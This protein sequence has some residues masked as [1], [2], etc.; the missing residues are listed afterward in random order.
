LQAVIARALR[1]DDTL[2]GRRPAEMAA[3]LAALDFE[4]NE[5]RRLRL[6][7]DAWAMRLEV[8]REYRSQIDAPIERLMQFRKWL[9]SVRNLD[10]PEV[11]FLKPL[12]DR[13]RLAHLEL[14]AVKPPPEAQGAH[15]QLAAAFHMVRQAAALRTAAVSSNDIKLAWDA[16]AAAAGALTLGEQALGELERLTSSEPSR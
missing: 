9:D 16:S 4:L 5:A 13:A 3:L 10:G 15:G 8:I 6:A 12:D 2:G 7:R 1:S 14:R 11:K